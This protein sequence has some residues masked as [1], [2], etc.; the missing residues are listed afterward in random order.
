LSEDL[1]FADCRRLALQFHRADRAKEAVA[2]IRPKV[3]V[4]FFRSRA[5]VAFAVYVANRDGLLASD[6]NVGFAV[7]RP[8]GRAIRR[9]WQD[10]IG[11][12]VLRLVDRSWD[13]V[14]LLAPPC[15]TLLVSA[16]L[17]TLGVLLG[18]V[19]LLWAAILTGIAAM[20]WPTGFMAAGLLSAIY[21]VL[22]ARRMTLATF[23][24]AT[25]PSWTWSVPL[26]YVTDPSRA[27]RMV[28]LVRTQVRRRVHAL[29]AEATADVDGQ[30]IRVETMASI[31]IYRR[32]IANYAAREVVVAALDRQPM[33]GSDVLL[34][35]PPERNIH[36]VPPVVPATFFF[37]YVGGSA[38]VLAIVA[39]VVATTERAACG[40]VTCPSRPVTYP[41][42]LRWIAQRLWFHDPP[43]IT[44]AT[45]QG[46]ILGWLT[47]A[48]MATG[49]GGGGG[50]SRSGQAPAP[51]S[52]GSTPGSEGRHAG[53]PRTRGT[54][55]DRERVRRHARTSHGGP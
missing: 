39:S 4:S 5:P 46:T 53:M 20:A 10:G 49:C 29:S 7:V 14:A 48:V 21:R 36:A 3:G 40:S 44:P 9:T 32:G 37:W 17:G 55:G 50:V 2:T 35:D 41:D 13:G 24:E 11:R 26:M 34:I 30:I 45:A 16:T 25:L 31:T 33:V 52:P 28:A 54:D 15:L 23:A 47:S 51:V 19:W 18:Q 43:G 42:A 27:D 12:G 22:R 6:P 1:T 8:H 38:V